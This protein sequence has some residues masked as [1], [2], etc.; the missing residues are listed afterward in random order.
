MKLIETTTRIATNSDLYLF[1]I[2]ADLNTIEEQIWK[3]IEEWKMWLIAP[4]N[5]IEERDLAS[6]EPP[7]AACKDLQDQSLSLPPKHCNFG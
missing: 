1:I 2:I 5:T 4:P 7:Q 3:Y 6:Q